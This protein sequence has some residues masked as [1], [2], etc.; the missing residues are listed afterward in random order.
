MV[1]SVETERRSKVIRS[2]CSL[3]RQQLKRGGAG[4]GG[5][6]KGKVKLGKGTGPGVFWNRGDSAGCLQV[7][8]SYSYNMIPF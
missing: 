7:H 1:A 8:V 5:G 3:P 6:I 2:E 4:R